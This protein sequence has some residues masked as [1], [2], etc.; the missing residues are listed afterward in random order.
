MY[1]TDQLRHLGFIQGSLAE[2]VQPSSNNNN[3]WDVDGDGASGHNLPSASHIEDI[4]NQRQRAFAYQARASSSSNNNT[5]SNNNNNG[6]DDNDGATIRDIAASQAQGVMSQRAFAH[7]APGPVISE[8][9]DWNNRAWDSSATVRNLE[10][11]ARL[12]QGP[13][14]SQNRVYGDDND[15]DNDSDNDNDNDWDD[16]TS[17]V[18]GSQAEVQVPVSQGTLAHQAPPVYTND[19][20]DAEAV[21]NRHFAAAQFLASQVHGLLARQNTVHGHSGDLNDNNNN[22]ATATV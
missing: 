3:D 2:N 10:A 9:S 13:V 5:N 17:Q 8:G 15:N 16:G 7:Q 6:W 22:S 14:I 21:A 12:V 11:Q 19:D 4:S 20:K 18:R 1:S